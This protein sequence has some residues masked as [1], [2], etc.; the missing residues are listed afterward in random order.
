MIINMDGI[1]WKSKWGVI[2]KTWLRINEAIAMYVS[3]IV[4][5]DKFGIEQHLLF[6]TE[7]ST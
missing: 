6:I 4:V 1:E 2:A 5:A 3:D 7:K